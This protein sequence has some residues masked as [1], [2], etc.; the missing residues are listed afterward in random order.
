MYICE[1]VAGKNK[2]MFN[3]PVNRPLIT[4][5]ISQTIMKTL[6]SDQTLYFQQEVIYKI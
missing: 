6:F 3:N 5:Y 1:P 2:E 4:I